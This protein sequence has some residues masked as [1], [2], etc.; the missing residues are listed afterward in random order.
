M[1]YRTAPSKPGGA[2][3]VL[4]IAKRI[5]ENHGG[6]M[7]AKSRRE[8]GARVRIELPLTEAARAALLAREPRY[9][10]TRRERA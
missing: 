1:C 9:S 10:E 8:G 6:R 4:A 5:D 7:G 2:G 3:L